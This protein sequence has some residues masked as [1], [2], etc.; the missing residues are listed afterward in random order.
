[1]S[2]TTWFFNL[3]YSSSERESALCIRWV[4]EGCNAWTTYCNAWKIALFSKLQYIICHTLKL[5]AGACDLLPSHFLGGFPFSCRFIRWEKLH[6]LLKSCCTLHSSS[7]LMRVCV[8]CVLTVLVDEAART[9][10]S[11]YSTL[12]FSGGSDTTLCQEFKRGSCICCMCLQNHVHMHVIYSTQFS[13]LTLNQHGFVRELGCK[14]ALVWLLRTVLQ[15]VCLRMKY[16]KTHKANRN[17][18]NLLL[19]E[20]G[21]EF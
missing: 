11:V 6:D 13:H 2:D 18:A 1:M 9:C 7:P 17:R 4:S 12:V 8:L 19:R 10:L 15:H 20:E 16:L 5:S 3:N 21:N 14:I